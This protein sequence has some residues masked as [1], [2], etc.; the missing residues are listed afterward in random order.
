MAARRWGLHLARDAGLAT[1][2][3][4]PKSGGLNGVR[5]P[6]TRHPKDGRR[7]PVIDPATGEIITD[8]WSWLRSRQTT[9]VPRDVAPDLPSTPYARTG[10]TDHA[11]LVAEIE[12]YTSLRF[13]GHERAVGRCP[14]HDDQHPSFGVI[15]GY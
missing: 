1:I 13:Y 5:A 4:F 11:D 10:R 8:P 6:L 14:F 12:R 2:E 3:V 7:H 9:R 15:G